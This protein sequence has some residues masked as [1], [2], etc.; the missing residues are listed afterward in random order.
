M[1][2][3]AEGFAVEGAGWAGVDY[4]LLALITTDALPPAFQRL[5]VAQSH[6]SPMLKIVATRMIEQ[7][8][9]QICG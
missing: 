1:E 8:L 7:A 5:L 6:V 2:N 4:S 3:R 9:C